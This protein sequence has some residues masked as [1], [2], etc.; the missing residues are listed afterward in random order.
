MP[1]NTASQSCGLLP[2]EKR[3][4]ARHQ[5][6]A[7]KL[8]ELYEPPAISVQSRWAV[9]SDSTECKATVGFSTLIETLFGE[10]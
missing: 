1:K 5:G 9:P 2:A 7:G 8:R 6:A 10:V 3:K 4:Q